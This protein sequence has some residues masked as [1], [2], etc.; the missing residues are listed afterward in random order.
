M[1]E[2]STYRKNDSLAGTYVLLCFTKDTTTFSQSKYTIL[3]DFYE[4]TY[5]LAA[6]LTLNYFSAKSNMSD[7]LSTVLVCHSVKRQ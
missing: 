6:H 1:E 2:R 5:K 3:L 4:K 7:L